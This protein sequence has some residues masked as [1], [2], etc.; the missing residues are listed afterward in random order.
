MGQYFELF[1]IDKRQTFGTWGNVAEMLMNTWAEGLAD[2]LAVPFLRPS[3]DKFILEGSDYDAVLYS[4]P[5]NQALG[6]LENLPLD[7]LYDIFNQID[8]FTDAIHF[9]LTNKTILNVGADRIETLIR[10][11]IAI[12]ADC[13]IICIGAEIVYLPDGLLTEDE[14]E[15]VHEAIVTNEDRRQ[16]FAGDGD[17]MAAFEGVASIGH[18]QVDGTLSDDDADDVEYH[19]DFRSFARARYTKVPIDRRPDIWNFNPRQLRPDR[20]PYV[21]YPSDRT[22]ILC[23]LSTGGYVRVDAVAEL[24]GGSARGPF[25]DT[26]FGIGQLLVYQICWSLFRCST[27]KKIKRRLGG[28]NGGWAGHR[29]EITTMDQLSKWKTE[30]QWVDVSEAMIAQM[31][32]IW[33]QWGDGWE[34][35]IRRKSRT[36]SL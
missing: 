31:K 10:S 3:I 18:D 2:V 1:N 12:W 34:E 35:L 11:S 21:Y 33:R 13:R 14:E 9:G 23:N 24:T 36:T 25:L 29:F 15:E 7:V 27:M 6:L 8:T 5:G 16:A 26:C 28:E 19:Q 20:K 32:K 17:G 22:W 4:V 30:A